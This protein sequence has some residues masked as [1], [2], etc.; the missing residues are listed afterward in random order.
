LTR[1]SRFEPVAVENEGILLSRPFE[2]DDNIQAPNELDVVSVSGAAM[3]VSV[4]LLP[5]AGFN[6]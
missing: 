4:E 3:P 5:L 6:R 2:G 1:S